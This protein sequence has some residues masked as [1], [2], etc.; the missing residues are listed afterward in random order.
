MTQQHILFVENRGQALQRVM[1]E[2]TA[3]R[4][5]WH[6]VRVTTS[7]AAIK[8]ITQYQVSIVVAGCEMEWAQCEQM[9]RLVQEQDAAVVRIALVEDA[10]QNP[11][12]EMAFAHQFLLGSCSPAR[13]EQTLE[14]AL[15]VWNMTKET[16]VLLKF[17]AGLESLP[18]PPMLYF[19]IKDEL[20]TLGGSL[21]SIAR[22]VARDPA[23]TA[24]I[25]RIANSGLYAMPRTIADLGT[26]IGLLGT[27][28]LLS[29][30]L[31]GPL[32]QP[33][34]GSRA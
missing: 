14:G 5:D 32:V 30:V 18:T 23:L 26:A 29:M 33:V 25:L 11:L 22:L 34:A 12:K 1:Q 27:E 16:P 20:D 31:R 4:P 2:L 9:F 21:Q 8:V 10:G 6:I 24:K 13:I 28:M 17:V 3:D 15:R 7:D 19:E